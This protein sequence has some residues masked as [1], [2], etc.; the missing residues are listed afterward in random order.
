METVQNLINQIWSFIQNFTGGAVMFFVY[1][2]MLLLCVVAL[3][4]FIKKGKKETEQSKH[5]KELKKNK[6]THVEYIE[7]P[8]NYWEEKGYKKDPN[9]KEA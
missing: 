4:F 7:R 9:F 2:S 1:A 3:C 8:P 5:E 6:R